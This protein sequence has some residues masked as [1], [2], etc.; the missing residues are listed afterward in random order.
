MEFPLP[1]TNQYLPDYARYGISGFYVMSTLNG[2]SELS[3]LYTKTAEWSGYY[4]D[5]LGD[6]CVG[7]TVAFAVLHS[8][9]SLP[10]FRKDTMV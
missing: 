5:V 4:F 7:D 9:G 8:N 3:E 10:G 6:P 1:E 2:C